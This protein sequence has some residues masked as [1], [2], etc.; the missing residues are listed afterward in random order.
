VVLPHSVPLATGDPHAWI[1]VDRR[2]SCLAPSGY[3]RG[4]KRSRGEQMWSRGRLITAPIAVATWR[5]ASIAVETPVTSIVPRRGL[6]LCSSNRGTLRS[7]IFDPL[8]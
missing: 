4:G 1:R 6:L 7:T 5:I 2:D 3:P 8:R